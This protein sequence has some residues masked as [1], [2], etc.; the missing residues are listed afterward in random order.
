MKCEKCGADREAGDS[1]CAG[2]GQK[3]IEEMRPKGVEAPKSFNEL[4]SQFKSTLPFVNR[5]EEMEKAL[6][7]LKKAKGGQGNGLGI[8]GDSG[9]GKSR[10]IY[11]IA[12]S[13]EAKNCNI[14]F[15]SGSIYTKNL[16]LSALRSLFS[17]L[18]NLLPNVKIEE[19]KKIISPSLT[20][21]EI[22]HALSAA[23][24]LVNF[25]P[26]DPE[27]TLLELGLK[28]RYVIDV[29]LQLLFNYIQEKPLIL[30]CVDLHWIDTESE[31]FLDAFLSQIADKKAFL[32]VNYRLEFRD[33]WITRPNYTQM[34]L[35]PLSRENCSQILDSMLGIDS[36]LNE[37]KEKLVKTVEGNPF[38]LQELVL[39]LISDKILLRLGP[40]EYRL[41][42]GTLVSELRLSEAITL[43]YRAKIDKL[44]AFER[45]ILQI[46]SVV[47]MKFL[48]SQIIQ[49]LDVTD[50]REIRTALN[51]LVEHKLI[52]EDRLYPESG[53]TFVNKLSFETASMSMLKNTRKVLHLKLLELLE[54]T[55][56]E[57]Q[58]DQMQIAAS[59]AFLGEDWKKAFYYTMKTAS[60]VFA[61][62]AFST[63]AELYEQ[64]LI[65]AGHLPQDESLN[66]AVMQIH[67]ELYHVLVPLGKFERQ[68]E[69]INKALKIA[70][71]LKDKIY[72]SLIYSAICIHYMGYKNINEALEYG[73][74]AY[75][76]AKELGS[77]PA[78]AIA[79]FALANVKLFMGNFKEVSQVNLELEKTIGNVD[80][81]TNL[82]K[83]PIGHLARTY[84]CWGRSFIGDFAYVEE[85][86]KSWFA[87]SKNLKEPSIANICRFGARGMNDYVRG[88]YERA[89]SDLT[90][91]LQYSITT[92]VVIFT[93]V[94]L[95]LLADMYLRKGE[96]EEGK[97]F[98][99]E[100][101]GAVKQI[102][103][104]YISAASLTTISECLMLSH[105]YVEAKEFCAQA[106]MMLKERKLFALYV[107]LVKISADID[108]CFPNPD[109]VEIK[110]KLD[111][112]MKL[113]NLF[114]VKPYLA[115]SYLT[116]ATMYLKQGDQEN[117]QSEQKKAVALFEELG[118]R[119]W[120]A[121]TK[122]LGT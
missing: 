34:L 86:C 37:I 35:S 90:I 24:S 16:P 108:L 89:L 20:K 45:T 44:D 62:N 14:L 8:S 47:G 73:E 76:I 88:E 55:L 36:T 67:Y 68:Y 69:H 31:G 39:S 50:E 25:T 29:G 42:E 101:I 64:A 112:A 121:R 98:L 46:A 4:V 117:F 80:Y 48:Y 13:E 72:E 92:G 70:L 77:V 85:L 81:Q 10:L 87:T 61:I 78:S 79:L 15:T 107:L 120:V 103:A 104:A 12:K 21:M 11:E 7:L 65:A 5:Q 122:A 97:K 26:T 100:A 96:I 53:F 114:G 110:A 30:I 58:V 9:S 33:S 2:C 41:K 28:K 57:D 60:K 74:K 49:L 75:K 32:L 118:M 19:A 106:M 102:H 82:L 17:D 105:E 93:P 71:E 99:K 6:T 54:K 109:F 116:L 113:F 40:K 95:A 83:L 66:K 59:H 38:F 18:F 23:L 91:A 63:S 56:V 119:Y 3:F 84:E 27:W 94:F 22:P 111:E 1:F 43:V 52:Y 51:N 115:R